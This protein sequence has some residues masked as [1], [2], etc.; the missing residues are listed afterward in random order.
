MCQ[1]CRGV[2][3]RISRENLAIVDGAPLKA[4]AEYGQ[5]LN[6]NKDWWLM[7]GQKV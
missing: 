2:I 7:A 1:F 5:L 4:D 3:H 6:K